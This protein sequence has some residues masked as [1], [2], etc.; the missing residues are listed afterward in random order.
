M[1]WITKKICEFF[2][3]IIDALV[4]GMNT[5]LAYLFGSG[6]TSIVSGSQIQTCVV[7][8]Q[9]IATVLV[10]LMVVKQLL[11]VYILETDGDTETDPLS[12][13]V[14]ASISLALIWTCP[15]I[16]NMLIGYAG[17]MYDY[18]WGRFN[19]GMSENVMNGNI[20][21]TLLGSGMSLI[22]SILF[23]AIYV[24]ALVLLVIKAALRGVELGIMEIVY[25]IFCVDM[26]T[27]SQE[28]WK[29]F[30]SSYIVVVFGY[31]IQ[32]L[33][34]QLSYHYGSEPG[35][36]FWF[37]LA[38]LFFAVKAPNWLEKFAYASGAGRSA[39]GVARSAMYM[40]PMLRRR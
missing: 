14:K 36:G 2:A 8:V 5:V 28:R 10:S 34:L 1:G 38:F 31:I 6:S 40:L 24:I 19:T 35:T 30:F 32:L 39:A 3:D 13:L 4:D 11:T 23:G 25:P 21:E 37:A 18:I 15:V 29:T 33:C 27:T 26:I 9:T 20:R 16:T 22:N 17:E 7:A 12:F